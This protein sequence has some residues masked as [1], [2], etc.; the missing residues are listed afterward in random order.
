MRTNQEQY[1][2]LTKAPMKKVLLELSVPTMVSMLITSIYNLSDTFFVGQISTSASA[3]VGVV[4]SLMTLMQAIGF[5]FGHGAGGNVS[6]KLGAKD[7]SA[8]SRFTSTSFFAS[9]ATGVFIMVFGLLFLEPMLLF[10]GSTTTILG[11]ASAYAFFILCGAPGLM[12]SLVLNNV[13]RYEGKAN[14]AMIGLVSGGVLNIILD[15]I[16]IFGCN[17]GIAGAGLAT[18]TSQLVSCAI[19]YSM[20]LR[21]KTISKISIRHITHKPKEFQQI[22]TTGLP[23]LARQGLGTVATISLNF[24]AAAYGDAAIAAMSIVTRV[25]MF[26]FSLTIGV[27]QGLQPIAG[28]NY[29]AKKYGRVREVC[30]LMIT[31]S[32]TLSAI[33]M[34]FAVIFA[35]PIIQVFRDDPAVI[36]MAVPAFR[37]QCIASLMIPTS[38]AANFLFQSIGK[39]KPATLL[40]CCR[41]GI[42]YFPLIFI[43]PSFFGVVGIQLAQPLADLFTFI[44]SASLLFPYLKKLKLAEEGKSVAV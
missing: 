18:A 4:A 15:P 24:A 21:G 23:S 1:D 33:A 5:T 27:G 11:D 42:C 39:S 34:V 30:L 8:A 20:F 31:V 10:L 7:S 2:F 35:A 13:L 16:F 28:F 36:A 43:L 37:Y 9:F 3:A 40:A 22:I 29:G 12:A 32:T 26:I 41:Q 6:R 14:F 19:L 44:L 17:L 25:F 38:T